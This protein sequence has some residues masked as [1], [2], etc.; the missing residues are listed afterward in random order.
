MTF[1]EQL[2]DARI[3]ADLCQREAAIAIG[4]SVRTY[5]NWEQGDN[6]PHA[7]VQ[8]LA[9][10]ALRPPK[11]ARSRKGQ[12]QRAH[13]KRRKPMMGAAGVRRH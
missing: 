2:K 12:N 3:A 8:S 7:S 11:S 6:T 1:A 9:L 13:P 5:Q 4:R 10:A